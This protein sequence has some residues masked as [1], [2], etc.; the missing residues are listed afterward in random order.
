MAITITLQPNAGDDFSA[1]NPLPII[2]TSSQ[3]GIVNI[4]AAIID[5]STSQTI[6]TIRKPIDIGTSSQFTIDI[7]P[8]V[9]SIVGFED[10]STSY[11]YLSVFSSKNII[12]LLR[13]EYLSGGLLVIGTSTFTNAFKVHNVPI[14]QFDNKPNNF[15]RQFLTN[16]ADSDGVSFNVPIG[17][18]ESFTTQAI[19]K[20]DGY[21][22]F[23]F[24][25]WHVIYDDGTQNT[26]NE[27]IGWSL[28]E[29]WNLAIGSHYLKNIVGANSNIKSYT[30]CIA[31]LG[32]VPVTE[33]INF[34]ISDKCAV[35][36]LRFSYLNQKGA[37]D[38]F[39]FNTKLVNKLNVKK[40]LWSKPKQGSNGYNYE[41][42]RME[43]GVFIAD[44][45]NTFEVISEN[46]KEDVSNWLS[47]ILKA[48]VVYRD[49]YTDVLGYSGQ[50]LV[51]NPFFAGGANW[52]LSVNAWA[53]LVISGG[54]A[55]L[56]DT[57][58]D[59]LGTIVQ[60]GI[61]TI[62]V[63][64]YIIM[65]V[66]NNNGVQI[67]IDGATP[68]SFSPQNGNLEGRF[69]ATSTSLSIEL[70]CGSPTCGVEILMVSVR[71]SATW[72]YSYR[73]PVII[74]DGDFT[75]SDLRKRENKLAF[76]FTEANKAYNGIG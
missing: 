12:I 32:N 11:H 29:R 15:N 57:V 18:S 55:T 42:S 21:G 65:T 27:V 41:L 25:Q 16:A 6:A 3:S 37:F 66:N 24:L 2:C 70:S 50:S 5:Q 20:S 22:G 51:L 43:T 61:L 14:S 38:T 64:Y 68:L 69:I 44:S 49:F 39:T 73:V 56:L 52:V 76:T 54:R 28:G 71:V 30:V 26:F 40:E 8:I 31:D 7:Y 34:V 72:Q 36:Q 67:T 33:K 19:K 74:N 53:S 17:S 59:A 63:E 60:T 13:E 35:S 9:Q 45:F 46:L 1:F 48:R 75:V 4:I 23:E 58:G 62:G 10:N 47:E